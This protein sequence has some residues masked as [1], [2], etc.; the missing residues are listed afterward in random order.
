MVIEQTL[1]TTQLTGVTVFLATAAACG[2]LGLRAQG[3]HGSSPHLWRLVALVHLV[4]AAE[5]V[6]G[7]RHAVHDMVNAVLRDDGLYPVRAGMQ[8]GLLVLCGLCITLGLMATQRWLRALPQLTPY[9][10]R[11]VFATWVVGAL[12]MVEAV[13]LHG[14]D[15]MLYA[16]VG[17]VRTIAYLW[18]CAALLTLASAWA[19]IYKK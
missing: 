4:F 3:R 16:S 2:L 12:F 10:R 14:I 5:V 11:A 7:A 8:A 9:A 19:E 1:N 18:G 6:F 17:P 13:S 15:Q